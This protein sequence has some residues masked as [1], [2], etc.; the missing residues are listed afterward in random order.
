M[1]RKQLID[2]TLTTKENLTMIV[3][4]DGIE[5]F[6]DVTGQERGQRVAI[7]LYGEDFGVTFFADT[8]KLWLSRPQ[9]TYKEYDR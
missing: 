3:K 2:V 7:N 9:F 8:E 1:G 6:Y 4:V 5:H